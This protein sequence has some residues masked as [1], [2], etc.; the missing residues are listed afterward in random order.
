MSEERRIKSRG[1]G[2]HVISYHTCRMKG[3]DL[4]TEDVVAWLQLGRNL[5]GSGEV[6]G[7]GELVGCPYAVGVAL[8]LDLGEGERARRGR[9]AIPC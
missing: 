5:D 4:V 1:E 6:V 9:C 2:G 3:D 7:L 8:G